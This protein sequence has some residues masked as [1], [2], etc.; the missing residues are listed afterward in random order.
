MERKI[1][2][3]LLGADLNCY[4]VARAF[5]E[6]YGV[7]SYVLG[8]Y[9]IGATKYSRMINF[10]SYP[11]LDNPERFVEILTDFAREHKG[12]D[13]ILMGCTDDYVSLV[14]HNKHLLTD[15]IIFS[16]I[17]SAESIDT[18]TY[19]TVCNYSNAE[20]SELIMA[21]ATCVM[22]LPY[23]AMA[24]TAPV[25]FRSASAVPLNFEMNSVMAVSLDDGT[26]QFAFYGGDL[27]VTVTYYA[28]GTIEN[29]L[30]STETET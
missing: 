5:H 4:N 8:R 6:S 17:E 22:V 25:S 28:D 1:V 14:V 18:P 2:P 29:S 3:V 30:I 13:L 20:V 12:E 23:A 19:Q 27:V 9:A 26:H 21:G 11:D 24:A 10:K 7:K 16:V 15:Y